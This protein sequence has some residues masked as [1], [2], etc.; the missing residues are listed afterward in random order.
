MLL[1]YVHRSQ[2]ETPEAPTVLSLRRAGYTDRSDRK[3]GEAV[4]PSGWR[5]AVRADIKRW[6][7]QHIVFP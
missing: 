4:K 3:L 2:K 7:S 1:V 5:L 6:K